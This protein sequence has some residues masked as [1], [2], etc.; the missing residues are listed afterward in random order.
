MRGAP[1][2]WAFILVAAGSGRR[3]GGEPKQFR[4]LGGRPLW[5]WSAR[6]ADELYAGG[7]IREAVAVFPPGNIPE[8]P[9][10]GACP[11]KKT[12]GGA[13]RTESVINGLR[14]TDA[15]FVMIHDAARPFLS[16]R[17]CEELIRNTTETRGTVPLL[18]S[19]D[20]LKEVRGE[21]ISVVPREKIFRTQTPQAFKR[22]TLLA[23]LEKCAGDASDEASLWLA[24]SRELAA[25]PGDES[26]F[27]ITTDFDWRT[28]VSLVN[29]ES[30]R[31]VG[32]GFDVHE[33]VP[34][35]KLILGGVEIDSPLGLLGHSD[36]DIICHAAADALLGAAGETDI[37]TLFPASD[38]RYKDADSTRILEEVLRLLREKEWRVIWIDVTLSAQ[39]PRIGA[40]AQTII[41]HLSNRFLCYDLKK[42]WSL[43]VKSGEYV[44]SVGRGE[45]MTCHAVATIERAGRL[46]Y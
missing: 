40:F 14:A 4:G 12:E 23:V 22:D 8:T 43:K 35:R 36:A 46:S 20:S 37:G 1:G 33:L 45:C 32:F 19:V 42:K 21:K 3:M 6:L 7:L 24:S 39:V 29:A 10:G 26:N 41:D 18:G 5:S 13:T 15:D 38:E 17:T 27:K 31:R 34:G 44:G 30:E 9:P 16:V 2:D 11:L 25:V 28:A